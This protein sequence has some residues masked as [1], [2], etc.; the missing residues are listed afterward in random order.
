MKVLNHRLHADDG[1]PVAF[2]RSPNQSSGIIAPEFL[3]MHYTAGGT[4]SSSVSWLTNPAAR[5]SAHL[6]IGRDGAITQLVAFNRKAWHAGRS[7]WAGRNGLNSF[8]IGI[9]LAN[10]GPLKRSGDGWKTAWGKP[11]DPTN[12]LE[13]THKNSTSPRG[14][15]DYPEAQLLVA[16]EVVMM[17]ARRYGLQDVLGHDDIAPTRKFDPGPAFPMDSFRGAFLGREEDDEDAFVTTTALN[18]RTG[19]GTHRD[20][21]SQ[22]PLPT[23]TRLAVVAESGVWREVTSLDAGL[24]MAGCMADSF[25]RFSSSEHSGTHRPCGVSV[26]RSGL[27]ISLGRSAHTAANSPSV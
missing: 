1:E 9:E 7:S 2:V 20:K 8:S 24:D 26:R 12:V 22:S 16:L 27:R 5:A 21:L 15:E 3:V 19:P 11:V 17:L 23:G 4:A 13:A 6:V 14:W 18:I 25:A 10:A